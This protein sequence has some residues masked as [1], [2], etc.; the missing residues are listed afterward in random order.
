MSEM[1]QCYKGAPLIDNIKYH[2]RECPI[3]SL[4]QLDWASCINGSF[5]RVAG[6]QDRADSPMNLAG[7][8]NANVSQPDSPYSPSATKRNG[9]PGSVTLSKS[10]IICALLALSII[11]S[12]SATTPPNEGV[13]SI[14]KGQSKLFERGAHDVK[15]EDVKDVGDPVIFRRLLPSSHPGRS[16][17][18][19]AQDVPFCPQYINMKFEHQKSFVTTKPVRLVVGSGVNATVVHGGMYKKQIVS[20]IIHSS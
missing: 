15:C 2:R 17:F 8:T 6:C 20:R 7:F 13:R 18:C 10:G 5:L 3:E 16:H 19:N 1:N 9:S 4:K 14:P 11:A 12:G